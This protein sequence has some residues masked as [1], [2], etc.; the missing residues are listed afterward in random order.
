MV[1][2]GILNSGVLPSIAIVL[3]SFKEI[4]YSATAC[5]SEILEH[6]K[7]CDEEWESK[8]TYNLIIF[9]ILVIVASSIASSERAL[10]GVMGEK[11]TVKLRN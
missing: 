3:A 6:Y 5:R 2:L 1:F 7:L 9:L 4:Y 10:F 11:L 8:R